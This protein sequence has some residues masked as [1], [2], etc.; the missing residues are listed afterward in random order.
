[1]YEIGEFVVHPG[2][3]VC[4]V[5]SIAQEPSPAYKLLPISGRN[6]M[7]IVYPMSCEG[8]LRPVLSAAEAE[9]LIEMYPT[10][11]VDGYTDR[12]A[13]LEEKHFKQ[14]MKHGTCADI[15]RIAK[16]FK[17]RIADVEAMNKKPPVVYERILKEARSRSL[18][19][20]MCALD[21]TDDEVEARFTAVLR[22]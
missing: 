3:G 21:E 14:V 5:V 19:E 22:A 11:E 10:M 17:E 13:I 2:Q 15:M 9:H 8:Q 20:L 1:M 12:S 7:M 16:T 18:E 6:P 4:R